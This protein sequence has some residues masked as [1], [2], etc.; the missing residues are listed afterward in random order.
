MCLYVEIIVNTKVLALWK[1]LKYVGCRKHISLNYDHLTVNYNLTAF[2]WNISS[3]VSHFY[4]VHYAVCTPS[5]SLS[6]SFEENVS[7]LSVRNDI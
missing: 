6:L 2:S 4:C 1:Y 5:Y 3:K 7:Y